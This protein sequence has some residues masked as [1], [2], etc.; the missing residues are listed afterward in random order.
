MMDKRT[1]TEPVN[2]Q[3]YIH[4]LQRAADSSPDRNLQC[5]AATHDVSAWEASSDVQTT[6]GRRFVLRGF[7]SRAA[8]MSVVRSGAAALEMS[9]VV[10]L[11]ADWKPLPRSQ[12]ERGTAAVVVDGQQLGLV[13]VNIPRARA[14]VYS[15][16][17]CSSGIIRGIN[18]GAVELLLT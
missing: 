13:D 17:K 10:G 8:K 2:L 7:T 6:G 16:S 9:G 11:S 3:E 4:K 5:Q 18:G 14:Q 15:A 1:G 12:R